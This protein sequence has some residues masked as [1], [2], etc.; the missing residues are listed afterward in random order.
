MLKYHS[1]IFSIFINIFP[2]FQN[3]L[4]FYNNF[5]FIWYLQKI[6]ASQKVDFPDPEGPIIQ[7]HSPFR[8][9]ILIPLRTCTFPKD[10]FRLCT[11]ITLSH[12][13]FHLFEKYREY[14]HN[15]IIHNSSSYQWYKHLIGS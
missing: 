10:F 1:Y 15:Q 4:P 9:S 7:T 2:F 3:A 12:S 8:I 5:S 11:L 6:Q 14:F 13:P